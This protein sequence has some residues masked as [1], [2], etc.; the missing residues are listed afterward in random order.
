MNRFQDMVVK[1]HEEKIPISNEL[2]QEH[3][4]NMLHFYFRLSNCHAR[5]AECQKSEL[6]ALQ[7][8]T[9]ARAKEAEMEN[10]A[11]TEG[12]PEMEDKEDNTRWCWLYDRNT[13]LD[14]PQRSVE[15]KLHTPGTL[16]IPRLSIK[17]HL[18]VWNNFYLYTN[19]S[20]DEVKQVK[21]IYG[22]DKLKNVKK[23]VQQREQQLFINYD[24]CVVL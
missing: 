17:L 13:D 6:E 23:E 7:S 15:Q 14:F 21:E 24:K 4:L 5:D 12:K 2:V 11:E 3:I 1:N 9:L 16:F 19:A 10:M 20:P 22:Q 8:N 18:K